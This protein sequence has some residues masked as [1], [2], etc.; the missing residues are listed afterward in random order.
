M[1]DLVHEKLM[2]FLPPGLADRLSS[3][4]SSVAVNVARGILVEVARALDLK[5]FMVEKARS[6]DPRDFSRLFYKALGKELRWISLWDSMLGA[7]MG[8]LE[9]LLFSLVSF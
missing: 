7:T 1:K 6:L 2:M 9:S 8:L 3:P 5:D 4:V